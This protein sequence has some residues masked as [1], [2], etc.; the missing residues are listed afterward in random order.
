MSYKLNLIALYL[1]GSFYLFA[2]NS[3]EQEQ[4]SNQESKPSDSVN[5]EAEKTKEMTEFERFKQYIVGDFDNQQQIDEEIE[6][7]KQIHPYAKHV[8]RA[9]NDRIDNLPEDFKGFFVIEESYYK[10]PEQD[11][12]LKPY[13]FLFEETKEGKVQLTNFK[14]PEDLDKT[15][16]RNDN[17]DLQFD[18]NTLEVSPSFK[19]VTYRYKE[20]EGFY[21]KAPNDLPN[22]MRFTLEETIAEETLTVMEL[23]EKEGKSLTPYDTPLLYKRLK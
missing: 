4:Q 8:N 18:Y 7:G 15:K 2:C 16:V 23:L 1:F 6:A 17:P 13:L 12:I 19:P 3:S 11:T 20:G 5:V 10:Y 14:L 22:N 9:A 21:L